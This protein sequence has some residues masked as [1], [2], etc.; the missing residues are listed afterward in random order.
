MQIKYFANINRK[1]INTIIKIIIVLVSFL[2]I[3]KQLFTDN[4]LN[5][6]YNHL[7]NVQSV[8]VIEF[9]LFTIFLMFVNWFIE[10]VKWRYL[11]RK[12]ENITMLKSVFAV[13]AGVSISIFTPNRIGEYGGRIFV[14]RAKESRIKAILITILG[15]LSQQLITI[16]V[17][18]FFIPF[19]AYI[20]MDIDLNILKIGVLID[21]IVLFCLIYA[22]FNIN[23][24]NNYLKRFSLLIKYTSVFE[25]YSFK[26]LFN[27]L[28]LSLIRYGI[29]IFQYY[30][31]L[32]FFGLNISIV[33]SLM[34]VSI[35]F[36]IMSVIPTIALFEIGVKGSVALFI[37]SYSFTDIDSIAKSAIIFSTVFIWIINL[38]IPAIMGWLTLLS[39]NFITNS[40]ALSK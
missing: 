7:Q 28:I 25:R 27:V 11:I 40:K 39:F 3:Y 36:F 5:L 6:V 18:G 33:D 34:M 21:V 32:V 13:F 12:V 35:L 10:A 37:F 22:F 31:V 1:W 2:Y 26:E 24:V 30:I 20:Y 29:F 14:L 4:K 17:A 15:S 8:Y 38:A 9:I 19:F 16:I 23:K